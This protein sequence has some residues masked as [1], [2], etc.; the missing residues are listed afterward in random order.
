MYVT[1]YRDPITPY[2]VQC[3]DVTGCRVAMPTRGKRRPYVVQERIIVCGHGTL[4]AGTGVMGVD[5]GEDVW[6]YHNTLPSQGILLPRSEVIPC[7]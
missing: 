6:V 4:P 2:V 7:E 5:D 3:S 1:T